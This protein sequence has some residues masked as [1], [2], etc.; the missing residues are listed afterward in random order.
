MYN[1]LL[2]KKELDILHSIL[3]EKKDNVECIR[4][5]KYIS[6]LRGDY[7]KPASEF[8]IAWANLS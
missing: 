4:L 3:D 1:L 2:T 5:K 7:K 6:R 8:I